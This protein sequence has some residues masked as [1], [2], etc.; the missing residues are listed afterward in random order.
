MWNSKVV[1]IRVM[2]AEKIAVGSAWG[3]NAIFVSVWGGQ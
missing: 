3:L 1:C 2:Y